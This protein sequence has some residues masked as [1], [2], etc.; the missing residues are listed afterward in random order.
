MA[1]TLNPREPGQRKTA[2]VTIDAEG[3]DKGK[4]YLIT[5]KSAYEAERW[6]RTLIAKL[7]REGITVP[8]TL[9]SEGMAAL[10]SFPLLMYMSWIDDEALVGS[11]MACVQA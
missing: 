5:E 4:R 10:P 1:T 11:L 7:A 9:A 8:T 6:S 3:R 2:F